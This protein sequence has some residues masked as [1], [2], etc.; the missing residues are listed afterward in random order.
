MAAY[1]SGLDALKYAFEQA[2]ITEDSVDD[3]MA[4]V[5]QVLDMHDDVQTTL[6]QPLNPSLD[7]E[8]EQELEEILNVEDNTVPPPDGGKQDELPTPPK[9]VSEEDEL[10][11]RLNALKMPTESPTDKNKT[12]TMHNIL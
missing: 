1:R 6:S 8:L 11:R 9:H 7:A 4:D 3:T 12:P 10:M 2:G 5:Q